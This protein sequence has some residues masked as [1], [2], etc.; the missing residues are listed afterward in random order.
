MDLSYIKA[1][2][3]LDPMALICMTTF[4]EC[5][6]NN[7]QDDRV[8]KL[9]SNWLKADS[10]F[11]DLTEGGIDAPDRSIVDSPVK[12]RLRTLE[13]HRQTVGR[14]VSSVAA[15]G[16]GILETRQISS[17]TD[18]ISLSSFLASKSGGEDRASYQDGK[19]VL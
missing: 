7:A 13:F 10:V 4:S 14:H 17:S 2:C 15:K 12:V 3:L 11:H 19:T 1:E 18:S 6:F 9:K 16:Q 5:Y 8:E